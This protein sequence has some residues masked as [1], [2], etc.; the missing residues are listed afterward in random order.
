MGDMDDAMPKPGI[1]CAEPRC[2]ACWAGAPTWRYALPPNM[3]LVRMRDVKTGATFTP[4][5]SAGAFALCDECRMIIDVRAVPVDVL[6]ECYARRMI[7]RQPMLRTIGAERR[8]VPHLLG[9][10]PVRH[11]LGSDP[12]EGKMVVYPGSAQEGAP[13]DP[14]VG[15]N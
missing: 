9:Q 6:P 2:D 10:T 4:F 15:S 7:N 11:V 8:A 13:Q 1:Y 12:M 5:K 14:A 3:D